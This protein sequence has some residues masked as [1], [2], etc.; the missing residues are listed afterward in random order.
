MLFKYKTV[1]K[2]GKESEGSIEAAGRDLAIS[3]LQRRGL[4]VVSIKGEEEAKPFWKAAFFEKVKTRE[5]VV[6]SRQ[7]STLFA[8]QVSALQSFRLLASAVENPLLARKLTEVGDDIQAGTTISDALA[9]HS[10]VF[11]EFYVSMVK[12]GEETG[13]LDKT[14]K[15]LADY[16]ERQY[17]LTSKTK[18]ALVYPIFVIFVF[19][20]V[21]ILMFTMVIPKL[22]EIILE[23]GQDIP[24]YTKVVIAMSDFFVNYGIFLLIFV[25]LLVF[26]LWRFSHTETGKSYLD[27]LKLSLP[28]LGT[29]FKKLYLSRI[30]DNLNTMISSGVPLVRSLEVTADVVGAKTYSDIMTEVKD[31]VQGGSSLSDAFA[32]HKDISPIM[33]AM[34]KVGEETG[35]LGSVLKTLSDFYERE[36][37][38]A[39]DTLV[40]LIEPLLMVVL[41][42]GVGILLA[43]VL[44]P[45]YDIAGGIS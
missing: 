16:L 4:I 9:R 37:Y 5:V 23:S 44:L 26:Y 34:V 10:D 22:S 14:F 41:G 39:V 27:R 25:I 43:S 20:A 18:N 35:A 2:E 6:L 33:I 7:I 12:A 1:D 11:S 42:L 28:G 19:F 30:A 29:L 13:A 21:M 45:I 17:D 15:F 31:D 36:V 3:A 38:A 8:A 40:G 24:F 32:K